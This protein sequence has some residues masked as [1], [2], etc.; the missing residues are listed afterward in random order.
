MGR[1]AGV[2]V[3]EVR[4]EVVP[5]PDDEVWERES[6]PA[7]DDIL[8]LCVPSNRA[9][10]LSSLLFTFCLLQGV[11]YRRFIFDVC[12]HS[13]HVLGERQSSSALLATSPGSGVVKQCL[14]WSWSLINCFTAIGQSAADAT[15]CRDLSPRRKVS[16]VSLTPK[17]IVGMYM[18]TISTMFSYKDISARMVSI[19]VLRHV[20]LHR[21]LVSANVRVYGRH[22]LNRSHAFC[23]L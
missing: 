9:P 21:F 14:R 4:E 11:C 8:P 17:Y 22:L 10:I 1:C 16:L 23:R 18:A 20:S 5:V 19:A 3:G 12:A 2:E 6:R 15:R 13:D 7:L